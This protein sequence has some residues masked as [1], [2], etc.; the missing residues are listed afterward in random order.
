MSQITEKEAEAL[1]GLANGVNG[2]GV[3]CISAAE[4]KTALSII[5]KGLA[6]YW[7]ALGAV[8]SWEIT[9]AG[10]EALRDYQDREKEKEAGV[11]NR[12]KNQNI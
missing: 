6:R 8:P 1:A 9:Q 2:G 7:T 4:S 3:F 11:W 10:Y 12:V 5:G